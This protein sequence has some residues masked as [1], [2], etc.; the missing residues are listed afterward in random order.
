[1]WGKAG[2]DSL[3]YLVDLGR[4]ISGF[5]KAV[6]SFLGLSVVVVWFLSAE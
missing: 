6:L 5:L 2:N 1:M 4:L 3:V